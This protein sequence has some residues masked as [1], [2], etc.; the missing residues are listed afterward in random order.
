MRIVHEARQ[1]QEA[2]ESFIQRLK[3]GCETRAA[4]VRSSAGW[5]ELEVH[6]NQALGFWAAC[7]H[8][9]GRDVVLLGL[10]SE[11]A[12]R[13]TP[14]ATLAFARGGGASQGGQGFFVH[15][16]GDVLA[17]WR[18]EEGEAGESLAA[19]LE[20]HGH[21]PTLHEV[22]GPEGQRFR[23]LILCS[24]ASPD[25]GFHLRRFASAL[26]D[27]ARWNA[28]GLGEAAAPRIVYEE[29]SSGF[30]ETGE[31]AGQALR[32]GV[33]RSIREQFRRFIELRALDYRLGDVPGH[34]I[35]LATAEGLVLAVFQVRDSLAPETLHS[36]VGELV[37]SRRARRAVRCLAVPGPL[38]PYFTQ[39]FYRHDINVI[40]YT[41]T[42]ELTAVLDV[43]AVF[44]AISHAG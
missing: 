32:R 28:L 43:E 15:F 27:H 41:L 3:D 5:E 23:A 29:A 40:P 4:Q 6:W 18:M 44:R 33:A 17:A 19:F 22:E 2:L 21:G 38:G 16:G 31:S 39:V 30:P 36:A 11:P 20:L 10:A 42:P 12:A 14:C 26:Y 35:V 8:R 1:A 9:E 13:V 7:L 24:V 34:D 25:A 37:L